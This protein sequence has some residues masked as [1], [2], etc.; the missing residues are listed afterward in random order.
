[1]EEDYKSRVDQNIRYNQTLRTEVDEQRLIQ[2]DRNRLNADLNSDL[3]RQKQLICD[4][5][6]DIHRANHEM[7]AS[8]DSNAS[9]YTQKT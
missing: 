8:Q 3:D 7:Q 6:M 9:L 2:N 4:R 5:N 1:M